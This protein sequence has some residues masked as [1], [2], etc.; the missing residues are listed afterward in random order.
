MKRTSFSKVMMVMSWAILMGSLT[1]CENSFNSNTEADNTNPVNVAIINASNSNSV[2]L[3]LDE[4]QSEIADVCGSSGSLSYIIAD[5]DPF[6]AFHDEVLIDSER[7]SKSTYMRRVN[8]KVSEMTNSISSAVPKT[9]EVDLLKAISLASKDLSDY[10]N[11]DIIIYGNGLS[12]TGF[13]DMTQLT[14][15]NQ[16]DVTATVDKLKNSD[17]IPDLAGIE[18][19]FY[20]TETAG[21]QLPL[22]EKEERL[23]SDLWKGIIEAGGGIYT[24]SYYLPDN[25]SV[26]D[27]AP[28]VSPVSVGDIEI[29][30]VEVKLDDIPKELP[31]NFEITIDEEAIAFVAGTAEVKDKELAMRKII[32]LAE[33]I[34]ANN[35]DIA[36]IG[37]TATVGDAQSSVE[38]SE[39][40]C[41]TIADLLKDAGVNNDI[42]IKGYGYS[43]SNPYYTHDIKDGALVP[44]IAAT[45]RK[46]VIIDFNSEQAKKI[47][48]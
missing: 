31:E 21:N 42:I 19:Q 24:Q 47:F 38:L 8:S 44:E 22:S 34:I 4:V 5:G 43:D 36:L 16:I 2:A 32:P 12:T 46:V 29:G 26:L 41:H 9:E 18:V 25:V 7:L 23:L 17:L 11:S 35:I 1:G 40:R 33:T 27:S 20:M 10:E 13:I 37:S 14:S 48:G 28:A 3:N 15:V 39:A 30:V 6:I 45:N